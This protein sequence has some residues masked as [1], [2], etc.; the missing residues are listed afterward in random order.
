MNALLY[1]MIVQ[2]CVGNVLFTCYV[3]KESFKSEGNSFYVGF[4]GNVDPKSSSQINKVRFSIDPVS[5]RSSTIFVKALGVT[6]A[7]SAP[8]EVTRDARRLNLKSPSERSKG[9]LISS[10]D[11]DPLSVI[12]YAEELQSSDAFKVLP[13]IKM[14]THY[15]EYYAVSVPISQ[16]PVQLDY[17][18]GDDMRFEGIEGN[19]AIVIV[20]TEDDTTLQITLTQSIRKVDLGDDIKKQIPKGEIEAGET[21]TISLSK[22][23]QTLYLPSENDLSG[24]HVVSDKPIMFTSGHECGTV[25]SNI[26][27]CDQMVEQI[28]PTSTWGRRFITAPF[29]QRQSGDIFK[30]VASKD[31]TVVRIS[32]TN[33]HVNP[34]L[35]DSGEIGEVLISSNSSCYF[36]SNRPIL[37]VQF[38]MSSNVDRVFAG[39]PFMV[40]VPP[41]EQYRS[42]YKLHSFRSSVSKENEFIGSYFMNIL[43]PV[44]TDLSGI[45]L[46]DRPV[47]NKA[48]EITCPDREEICAY[49][50]L[51]SDV[52]DSPVL[53]HNSSMS[54]NAIVYWFAFRVGYGYFAGMTQIPIAC[55]FC[56]NFKFKLVE[57]C[58]VT[59]DRM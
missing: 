43:V 52:T 11:G 58:F 35:L 13:C 15:Y 38:S 39:D 27:F 45:R 51:V 42:M 6:N 30:M 55:E 24:S 1:S 56:K 31:N 25:P 7:M 20:T 57:L 21:V 50:I 3:A 40:I 18:Y 33:D 48:V 16:I 9:V 10:K 46:N 47:T 36:Q 54:I 23:M 26:S 49:S 19:S 37:L 12:A 17:D 22:R 41:V 14:P 4:F 29:A 28:P 8:E 2:H 32:C 5:G 59:N 53:S 34:V 44:K